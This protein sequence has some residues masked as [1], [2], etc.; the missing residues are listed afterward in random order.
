MSFYRLGE[1]S[2]EGIFCRTLLSKLAWGE[3]RGSI[4][5]DEREPSD[6]L[7]DRGILGDRRGSGSFLGD[8]RLMVGTLG[9]FS[10][11]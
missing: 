9:D 3:R 4:F 7:G 1:F 8:D 2:S 10:D 11:S 5:L 6:C